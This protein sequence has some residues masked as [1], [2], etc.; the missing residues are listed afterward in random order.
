LRVVA[1]QMLS[2]FDW[3]DYFPS[4]EIITGSYAGGLY[5]ED[6]YREVNHLG[7]AH[8]MRCFVRNYVSQPSNK[9]EPKVEMLPPPEIEEYQAVVCDEREIEML[10]P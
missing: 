10:R 1:E 8:V 5:Y 6:D 7:V 9:A 3:V 2:R 4:Y